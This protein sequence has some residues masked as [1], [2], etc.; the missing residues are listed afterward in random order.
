[1]S[2]P[3]KYV[4]PPVVEVVIVGS[5]KVKFGVLDPDDEVPCRNKPPKNSPALST[6]V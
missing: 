2:Y 3:K 6:I 1:M 5:V 4:L